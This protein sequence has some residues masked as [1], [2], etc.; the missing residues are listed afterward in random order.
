MKIQFQGIYSAQNRLWAGTVEEFEG[1][2]L[3]H[4]D[5]RLIGWWKE[6]C[7]EKIPPQEYREQ[8]GQFLRGFHQIESDDNRTIAGGIEKLFGQFLVSGQ[9]RPAPLTL[10]LPEPGRS[11]KTK[12]QRDEQAKAEFQAGTLLFKA[13][14]G[15]T[16]PRFD[17]A[18]G[19]SQGTLSANNTQYIPS[20]S[21]IHFGR[22]EMY[23]KGPGLLYSGKDS[24]IYAAGAKDLQSSTWGPIKWISLVEDRQK[25]IS[26][27]KPESAVNLDLLAP[28]K[29]A[30][31]GHNEV[32]AL[33]WPENLLGFYYLPEGAHLHAELLK[34][35]YPDIPIFQFNP[36]LPELVAG[37]NLHGGY[38]KI[39]VS[40][41]G[42]I[43]K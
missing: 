17:V 8:L 15:I 25:R 27:G 23:A 35:K 40:L 4:C 5:E 43:G 34:N 19:A 18:T 28:A 39:R 36:D 1:N 10:E 30:S 42:P 24:K 6:D 11:S 22:V 32:L 29:L 12:Q 13:L 9:P 26:A 2:I 14:S 16:D 20:A 41:P 31:S 3:Q 7:K 37:N 21:L 33:L 38:R